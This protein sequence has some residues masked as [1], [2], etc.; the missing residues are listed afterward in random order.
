LSILFM[1][2]TGTEVQVLN[3]DRSLSDDWLYD[4]VRLQLI[5]TAGTVN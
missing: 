5:E 4:R 1:W 2:L 3:I